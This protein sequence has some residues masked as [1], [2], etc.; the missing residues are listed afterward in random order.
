[1]KPSI[2]I[3]W[4]VLTDGYTEARE[5][6]AIQGGG[7]RTTVRFHATAFLLLHPTHGPVL[8]DTGY[9]HRFALATQSPAARIYRWV[10]PCTLTEPGGIAAV[11]RRMGHVDIRHVI[12]T[13]FHA[14]HIGGMKDFPHATYYCS[15]AAWD[16]VKGL[17]GFAAT[18]HGF[19]PDLV[20]EDFESRVRFIS[21]QSP[22]FAD[23]SL[24]I[25]DLPGHAPGQIGLRFLSD[26]SQPVLLAADACWL[27][28]AF[29]EN[30]M[31][32]GITRLLHGWQDYRGSLQRLHDLH[33]SEPD[34][35]IVPTH[36]PETAARIVS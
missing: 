36:C 31:P 18:R 34:L 4:C 21:E 12:L 3:P 7:W 16:S 23:G 1:M 29:R 24:Q 10:A 13:H 30:R 15:A 25:L 8:V 11:L 2:P 5:A 19:L 9:S 6:M 14:D 32:N 17:R 35:L 33:R 26:T 22:L 27:S 20:P 28:Q